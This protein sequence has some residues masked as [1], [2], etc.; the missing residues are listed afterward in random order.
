MP[1]RSPQLFT[2]SDYMKTLSPV[3]KIYRQDQF[4]SEPN[5]VICTTGQAV[6][7]FCSFAV[8]FSTYSVLSWHAPLEVPACTRMHFRAH[9]GCVS[10]LAAAVPAHTTTTPIHPWLL[11]DAPLA[12]FASLSLLPAEL[13]SKHL[14]K[15]FRQIESKSQN[16]VG[17]L[18]ICLVQIIN[19]NN[20]KHRP[21]LIYS[22]WSW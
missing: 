19:P 10:F 4:T 12:V 22:N 1:A 8:A 11:T 3:W 17:N 5:Y 20:S 2:Q 18:H 13:S 16:L 6:R 7:L 15:H 21:R 9:R 14:L